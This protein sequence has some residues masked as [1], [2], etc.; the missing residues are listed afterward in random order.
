MQKAPSKAFRGYL[1]TETQIT[2]IIELSSVR[3]LI[4]KNADAP[5]MIFSYRFSFGDTVIDNRIRYISMKPNIFFKLFEIIVIEKQDVEHV[6]QKMLKDY[7]WAWKTLVYGLTG[8]IDNIIRLKSR[9]IT[10]ETAIAEQSPPIITGT[11]VKYQDGDKKDASH[12]YGKPF[13]DSEAIDHFSIDLSGL[14]QFVKTQVDRPRNPDLFQAPYC[15]VRRGLDM[16]NYTMRAAYSEESFVFREAFYAIKGTLQQ[17]QFLLNITGLLNSSAYAYFNLM[18]D[19]SLGIEREQ[20]QVAE[21]L[22]FPYVISASTGLPKNSLHIALFCPQVQWHNTSA[23]LE[24]AGAIG[25]V[26]LSL[27]K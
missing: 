17:S 21:V 4:F 26:H 24:S 11:G 25:Q 27:P 6:Q 16:G 19:S 14:K 5:A 12:L 8:D 22:Q 7:D 1:L 23:L 10:L 13:L 3:K 9:Y 2:S 18:I 15:L 20:R